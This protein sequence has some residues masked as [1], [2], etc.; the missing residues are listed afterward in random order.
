M[1]D[2]KKENKKDKGRILRLEKKKKKGLLHLLFSRTLLI[3]LLLAAQ[4]LLVLAFYSWLAQYLPNFAA[5]VTVF[6]VLMV[7]VLFNM[8]MDAEAKLTWMLIIAVLPIFGAS[9]LLFTQTNLGHRASKKRVGQL[10]GETKNALPQNPDVLA[11]LKSDGSGFDDLGKYLSR[12]G[13]FPIYDNEETV[14]YPSGEVFIEAVTEELK[15]AEKYIFLEF[16]IIEEG[17][18]WGRVL[19]ILKEK[20][21]Q[22]ID[23][24]VMYDGMCEMST[25]P[26][27]YR[28]LL[29]KQG[30]PAKAFAPIR[31]VVSSHYNYRD[32]RKILVIDGKTAFTGGINLADEYMNAK[33]RFGYWKDAAVMVRGEAARSFALLFLQMWNIDEKEPDFSP[34]AVGAENMPEATAA[35][36]TDAMVM[37]NM[38]ERSEAAELEKVVGKVAD[39]ESS[40][41]DGYIM[42]FGDS[43]L[44][45]D[46]VGETV[47]M[48]MLYRANDYVHIMTPY[49]ILDGELKTAL[50]YAAER[51]VEVKMILPGIPDKK[52]AYALA[53]SHYRELTNSGVEIYEYNPGFVHAKVCVSDGIRAVVGTINWDYRSLYHHFECAAYLYRA[54]AIADA[55]ADFQNTLFHCRRVTPESIAHEKLFYRI[56]G[57]LLQF[58]APLM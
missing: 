57:W 31:P 35:M 13:C 24:R 10:I 7:G 19:K 46:K 9:F 5:V 6:T 42:P 34:L 18:M 15:K 12:S 22:G 51:G 50:K 54:K 56:V 16:F 36:G 20:I 47:Y 37:E 52:A 21:E 4:F 48:D 58:T 25:L 28:K 45:E 23:V 38:T 30:I 14:Y 39:M 53:K 40:P 8:E 43:P 32:H 1:F 33:V 41:K 26:M 17:E 29:K 27:N 2:K 44:D 3:F 55:E 49:L 11:A